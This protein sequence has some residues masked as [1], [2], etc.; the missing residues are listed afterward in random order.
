MSTY[1]EGYP[2]DMDIKTFSQDCFD[3][4]T[5]TKESIE[6]KEKY[7]RKFYDLSHEFIEDCINK[8]I[9]SISTIGFFFGWL[10]PAFL[11]ASLNT[12]YDHLDL[13]GSKKGV[14]KFEK[15]NQKEENIYYEHD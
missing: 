1:I 10:Y 14:Y 8:R 11:E 7:L 5:E 6:L 15:I 13:S 4:A 2:K 3:G 12:S 9:E